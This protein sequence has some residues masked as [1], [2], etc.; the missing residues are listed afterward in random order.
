MATTP[1]AHHLLGDVPLLRDQAVRH[2]DYAPLVFYAAA[3][4]FRQALTF[5]AGKINSR[6]ETRLKNGPQGATF[7]LVPTWL[8]RYSLAVSAV[9][10]VN[11]S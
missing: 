5:D 9:S 1:S 3:V 4:I 10:A 2:G 6:I 7:R 8:F 11:M